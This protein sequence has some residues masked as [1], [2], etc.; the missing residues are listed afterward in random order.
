MI[1]KI[2]DFVCSCCDTVCWN[3]SYISSN[4]VWPFW[5]LPVVSDLAFVKL[6]EWVS[7]R[8]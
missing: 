2:Y 5:Y 7:G 4:G 8:V 6:L 1:V 3:A